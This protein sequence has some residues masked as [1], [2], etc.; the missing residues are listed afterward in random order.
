MSDEDTPGAPVLETEFT[1]MIFGV[2]LVGGEAIG[3]AV[4][5]AVGHRGAGPAFGGERGL[6]LRAIGSQATEAEAWGA[7]TVAKASTEPVVAEYNGPGPY[8]MLNAM[9]MTAP[10]VAAAKA[11]LTAEIHPPRETHEYGFIDWLASK[12]YEIIPRPAA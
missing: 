7:Y 8:T 5:L 10:Q 12:G 9:G 1:H 11:V 3:N 2:C 6:A 4:S